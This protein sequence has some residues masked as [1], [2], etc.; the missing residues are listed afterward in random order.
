METGGG[1]VPNK[2]GIHLFLKG[3]GMGECRMKWA[4]IGTSTYHPPIGKLVGYLSFPH[5]KRGG[6]GMRW[7]KA[8]M[9]INHF[10]KAKRPR[11]VTVVEWGI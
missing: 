8:P 2:M 10:S 4:D 11:G 5:R 9:G 1:R 6:Y 3:K 7:A